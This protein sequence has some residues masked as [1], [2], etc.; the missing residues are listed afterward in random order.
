M[1]YFGTKTRLSFLAGFMVG[2][3]FAL[4][5][6]AWFFSTY[7]EYRTYSIAIVTTDAAL[8]RP[9]TIPIIGFMSGDPPGPI[10][11]AQIPSFATYHANVEDNRF[12]DGFD[13]VLEELYSEWGRV[14][15]D[16]IDRFVYLNERG[17]G[18][19]VP[20]F[21]FRHLVF[22]E[23]DAERVFRRLIEEDF[24]AEKLERCRTYDVC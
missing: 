5:H 12:F 13:A 2:A 15:R 22:R 6:Y 19:L 18:F 20:N 11:F 9:S 24:A 1:R 16:L 3:S 4:W 23:D 8:D 10:D 14:R 21:L 7:S 17:L